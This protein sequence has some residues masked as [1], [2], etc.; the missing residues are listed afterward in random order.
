MKKSKL[1]RMSCRPRVCSIGNGGLC[2]RNV[3]RTIE[4]LS[5]FG[6]YRRKW[7]YNEDIFFAYFGQD[8]EDY[9]PPVS[10]AEEF[11]LEL[12]MKEQM[13]KGHIPFGVHKWEE[14]YPD[15]MEDFQELFSD[16]N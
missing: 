13:K 11:A 6:K 2:L 16:L 3:S 1:I 12:R 15:L 4:L 9:L 14:W 7:L 8:F 5:R 10:I